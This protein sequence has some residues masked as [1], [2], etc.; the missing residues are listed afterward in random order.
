[1]Y[2]NSGLAIYMK[3]VD[4]F[5]RFSVGYFKNIP[6]CITSVSTVFAYTYAY[7]Y[8]LKSTSVYAYAY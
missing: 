3:S 6:A 7:M 2:A 4:K 1:M 8:E 5:R